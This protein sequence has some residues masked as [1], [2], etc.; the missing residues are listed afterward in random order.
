MALFRLQP[1]HAKLAQELEKLTHTRRALM[2]I[3]TG[4]ATITVHLIITED[5][6]VHM[7]K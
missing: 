1:T 2:G 5:T 6:V 7:T 3:V 4:M